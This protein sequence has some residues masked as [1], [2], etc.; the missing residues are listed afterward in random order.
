MS[1]RRKAGRAAAWGCALF[2]VACALPS[3]GLF[4]GHLGTSLF[5]H[6]GDSILAG[7]VPY[8]DFSLEYPPGSLPAFAVPSHGQANDFET[9]F[10][11]FEAAS[12][13]ACV[14]LV[15]VVS[16]SRL[17]AAYCA[18][19]P[20]ALGPLALHRYD[21]WAA[22]LATAGV[23]AVAW[24]RLRLGAA[25]LACGTAAK[26]FPVVLLP[27]ALVHAGR[28]ATRRGLGWFLAVLAV[29]VGPFLVLGAGGVRFSVERQLGRALQ[30]ETIGSAALLALHA[31]GAY[32]PRVV[33]GRGS[34]NLGGGLPDALAVLSTVLQLAAVGLVWLLYARGPR[35]RERFLLAAAAAVAAWVAFGK[36]L[37]PQFLLW[38][39]PLVALL[40]RLRPALLLLAVLGL[41]QAVYPGRYDE[42]VDLRTLPIVLLAARDALLLTLAAT[43]I[44]ELRQRVLEEV[45]GERERAEASR[46]V[47]LESSERNGPDRIP[48]LEPGGGE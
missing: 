2:V 18:L 6:Y 23:A 33:F 35:T 10:M 29:V 44:L 25:A 3:I 5:R 14:A 28:Q 17:A 36:V 37:S 47:L 39:V 8:R 19:A 15:A 22:A 30:L 31:V 20:L 9:W 21:L 27:L 7:K 38:L 26:I 1:D 43:L 41:S 12:G 13:L 42:L 46:P 32:A 4:R 16:R 34:W 11:A 40:K 24:G 48:G 45:G